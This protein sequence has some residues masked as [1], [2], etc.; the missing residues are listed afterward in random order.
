MCYA[1]R[2]KCIKAFTSLKWIYRNMSKYSI[3]ALV[4]IIR[5][6]YSGVIAA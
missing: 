4:Y 1:R 3:M 2:K 5:F 6:K